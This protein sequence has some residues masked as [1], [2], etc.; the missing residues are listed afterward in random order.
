[1]SKW[2]IFF[3][4]KNVKYKFFNNIHRILII[5]MTYIYLSKKKIIILI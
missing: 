2:Y 3:K 5:I 1:M 4:K